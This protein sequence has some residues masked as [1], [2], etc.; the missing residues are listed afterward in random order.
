MVFYCKQVFRAYPDLHGNFS[1]NAPSW[2]YI[3][4]KLAWALYSW[5]NGFSSLIFSEINRSVI[6]AACYTS[7]KYFR[8]L[9]ET[10]PWRW[11]LACLFEARRLIE[12]IRYLVFIRKRRAHYLFLCLV[13]CFHELLNFLIGFKQGLGTCNSDRDNLIIRTCKVERFRTL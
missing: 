6:S 5:S 4:P 7:N 9:F 11:D 10:P 12:K 3:R 2:R 8:G 1:I 13:L